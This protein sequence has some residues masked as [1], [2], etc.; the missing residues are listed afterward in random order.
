MRSKKPEISVMSWHME[1]GP[2]VVVLGVHVGAESEQP[3]HG[4]KMSLS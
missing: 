1:L 2:V 4:F 3:L